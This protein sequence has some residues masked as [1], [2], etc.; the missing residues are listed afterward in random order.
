MREKYEPSKGLP[1]EFDRLGEYDEIENKISSVRETMEL[2]RASNKLSA[3]FKQEVREATKD[4]RPPD[5]HLFLLRADKFQLYEERK[6][7]LNFDGWGL[8]ETEAD[9]VITEVFS[10]LLFMSGPDLDHN[11]TFIAYAFDDSRF[12]VIVDES[13]RINI[14][15]VS[16]TEAA[17]V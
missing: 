7:S 8:F 2:L 17:E 10:D 16:P 3:R 5:G 15:K 12:A 1:F 9:Q 6:T 4:I 14:V 13:V 11:Y